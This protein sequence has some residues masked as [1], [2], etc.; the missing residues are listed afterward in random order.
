MRTGAECSE[1]FVAV[2]SGQDLITGVHE[3]GTEEFPYR[4]TIIKSD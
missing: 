4:R 1:R 2:L 3:D